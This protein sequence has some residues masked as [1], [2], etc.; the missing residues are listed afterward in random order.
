MKENLRSNIFTVLIFIL[1]AFGSLQFVTWI[2]Q[3]A[4]ENTCIEL[5]EQYIGTEV[6]EVI[7]I[8]ENAINFGKDLENY[9]GMDEQLENI[10][11]ISEGNLK[12]VV[13]DGTGKPLYLSF[14]QKEENK[15]LLAGVY[16]GEY[17]NAVAEVMSDKVAG[18]QIPIGNR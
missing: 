15:E 13:L 11:Q 9:Y 5:Q 6:S 4:F 7:K 12:V 14:Q 2:S 16:S 8:V 3:M 10:C 17:Q 18:E 1:L